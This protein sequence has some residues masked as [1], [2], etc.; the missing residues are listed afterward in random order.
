MGRAQFS[1]L[2]GFLIVIC[3][4]TPSPHLLPACDV[5]R[6]TRH[7]GRVVGGEEDDD[8]CD[9]LVGAAAAEGDLLLVAAAHLLGGEVEAASILLV[10]AVLPERRVEEVAG[11]DGVDADVEGREV[12]RDT[13]GEADAAELAR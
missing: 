13:L 9:I 8:V 3:R 5:D 10:E 6:L 4:S 2:P 11:A 12:E 7:I 1:W